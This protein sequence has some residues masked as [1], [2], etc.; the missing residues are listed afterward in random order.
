M[1]GRNI[2][3]LRT[4][5]SMSQKVL[6]EKIGVSQGAVYFWEKEINEPTVGYIIKLATLFGV[7]TDELLSYEVKKDRK[8]NTRRGEMLAMFDKLSEAQQTL[9]IS[10]AKELLHK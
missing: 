1:F 2:K 6:A 10:T 4:E 3:E 8:E 9:L 5:R 7:S